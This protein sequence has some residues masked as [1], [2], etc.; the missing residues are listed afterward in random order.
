MGDVIGNWDTIG[1]S[2]DGSFGID[3]DDIVRLARGEH[4]GA[5]HDAALEALASSPAARDA[6][7]IARAVEADARALAA[8][9][10]VARGGNVVALSR[11]VARDRAPVRWAM[12]A[13]VGFVAVGAALF[14]AQGLRPELAQPVA[15]AAPTPESDLIFRSSDEGLAST[16]RNKPASDELFVDAFGG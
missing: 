11:P 3:A 8:A 13:A 5:R 15:T 6:F 16:A 7:R 2:R 1:Q 10:A 12:A 9:I 14:G 4:L